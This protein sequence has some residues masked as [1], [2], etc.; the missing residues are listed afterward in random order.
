MF[1]KI[2]IIAAI[3]AFANAEDCVMSG[4]FRDNKKRYCKVGRNT[5]T[6]MT[7]V[8][9]DSDT[10]V[11]GCRYGNYFKACSVNAKGI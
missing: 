4:S 5:N 3:A 1:T 10:F 7:P 11:F 9:V 8:K 2:A 6:N